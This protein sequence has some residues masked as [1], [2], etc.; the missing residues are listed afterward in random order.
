MELDQAVWGVSRVI[1]TEG[2][3]DESRPRISQGL[4]RYDIHSRCAERACG[5]IVGA[6]IADLLCYL[7]VLVQ[8][9]VVLRL[10]AAKCCTIDLAQVLHLGASSEAVQP[11][12]GACRVQLPRPLSRP[13]PA[14]LSL[15]FHG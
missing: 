1:S 15:V 12:F 10:K 8:I 7:L 11:W 3:S 2:K 13:E 5:L 6:K 4:E 9:S 14:L